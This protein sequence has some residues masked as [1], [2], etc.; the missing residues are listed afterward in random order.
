MQTM[1]R[2]WQCKTHMLLQSLMTL[3]WMVRCEN[4]VVHVLWVSGRLVPKL[5]PC[6][7]ILKNRK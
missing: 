2:H 5:V 1:V 6:L 3:L 7:K 4:E